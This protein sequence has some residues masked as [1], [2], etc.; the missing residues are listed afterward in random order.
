MTKN[1]SVSFAG[2]GE[3][4]CSSLLAYNPQCLTETSERSTSPRQ[5]ISQAAAFPWFLTRCFHPLPAQ[6]F[7]VN[8][9]YL[10]RVS[11]A[12]M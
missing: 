4:T 3:G 12:C 10:R 2:Q 9:E 7:A 5:S 6:L 1:L 8:L 11:L